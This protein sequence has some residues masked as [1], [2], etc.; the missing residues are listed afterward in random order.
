MMAFGTQAIALDGAKYGAIAGT[1]ATWSISSILALIEAGM[2]LPIG[3]FYSIIGIALGMDNVISASYIGFG[4]HILTGTI[5]GA[6]VG[7]AIVRLV[8][9]SLFRGILAGMVAGILI[10]LIVFLPITA[11]LVQPSMVQIVTLLALTTNFSISTSEINQ[12]IQTAALTSVLFHLVWGALFGFII[13]SVF[14]IKSYRNASWKEKLESYMANKDQQNTSI[15]FK[16]LG[17]GMLAGLLA[18]ACISALIL[19]VEKT[20]DIPVGTFYLVLVSSLTQSHVESVNMIVAGLLLHLFT[21]TIIGAIISIPFATRDSKILS[22]MHKYAP[23]Y[24]LLCGLVVW[25]FLFV[26]VTFW[27]I[28]PLLGNLDQ[29]QFIVQQ[30]PVG[31]ASSITVGELLSINDKIL[32]GALVFNMF[33]GLVTSIIVKSMTG[34]LVSQPNTIKEVSM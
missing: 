24:G 34:K 8:S 32:I 26:P 16:V 23:I 2:G 13:S 22:I 31:T 28:I 27:V 25:A 6:L 33:Y 7:S 4:L 29:D 9:L 10:W 12:F 17:F 21:G 30:T 11:F 15:K 18:S 5:M 3:S 20:I 14:R 1:I 19:V